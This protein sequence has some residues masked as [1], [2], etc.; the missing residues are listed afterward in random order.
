[1]RIDVNR[2]VGARTLCHLLALSV[3][4]ETTAVD[5]LAFGSLG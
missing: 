5:A 4:A 2:G 3:H 1:V